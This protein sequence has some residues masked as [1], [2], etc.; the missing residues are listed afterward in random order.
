M[1]QEKNSTWS[2]LWNILNQLQAIYSS[3]KKRYNFIYR[4]AYYAVR[5]FSSEKSNTLSSSQKNIKCPLKS[6]R[7]SKDISQSIVKILQLCHFHPRDFCQSPIWCRYRIT[8][9]VYYQS[10]LCPLGDKAALVELYDL[11][12]K[13]EEQSSEKQ[14]GHLLLLKF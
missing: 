11:V 3:G 13:A 4:N 14:T 1:Y 2:T 6:N 10:L 9:G 5:W 7:P 8:V 12:P